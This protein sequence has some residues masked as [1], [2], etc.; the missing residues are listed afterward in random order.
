MEI[1][2]ALSLL[3]SGNL[4]E[5]KQSVEL[6]FVPVSEE[7]EIC[8]SVL[9]KR[10]TGKPI[11]QATPEELD[12][13]A[14]LISILAVDTGAGT[15]HLSPGALLHFAKQIASSYPKI[16]LE[17]MPDALNGVT[18][19]KAKAQHYGTLSLNYLLNILEYYWD[20]S[21]RA[22]QKAAASLPEPGGNSVPPVFLPDDDYEMAANHWKVWSA[23]R[24][25]KKY[26]ML[27]EFMFMIE[28]VL[29]YHIEQNRL[30]PREILEAWA[31]ALESGRKSG[32]VRSEFKFTTVTMGDTQRVLREVTK[33]LDSDAKILEKI[34]N[35]DNLDRRENYLARSLANLKLIEYLYENKLNKQGNG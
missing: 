34:E 15:S 33:D 3:Q 29:K 23:N 6:G 35:W 2:N 9:Q 4:P 17:E 1:N 8:A 24:E 19:H 22:M 20:W 14:A 11:S 26:R 28:P 25:G 13:V 21:K 10:R 31:D 32:F 16:R 30:T 27:P 18:A 5:P 7:V 12:K